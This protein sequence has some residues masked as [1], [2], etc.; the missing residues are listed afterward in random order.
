MIPIAAEGVTVLQIDISCTR[1]GKQ[2]IMLRDGMKQR[3][4]Q[5]VKCLT[6]SDVQLVRDGFHTLTSVSTRTAAVG[7]LVVSAHMMLLV[8]Y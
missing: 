1:M 2:G 3:W 8:A 6:I 7:K 5:F 4:Q